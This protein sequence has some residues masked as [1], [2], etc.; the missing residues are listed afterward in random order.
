MSHAPENGAD[1]LLIRPQAERQ[2]GA[3]SNRRTYRVQSTR[4]ERRASAY[5]GHVHRHRGQ[6]EHQA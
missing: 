6:P 5:E 3:G 1:K 2:A 4:A